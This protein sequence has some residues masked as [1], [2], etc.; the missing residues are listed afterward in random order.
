[1]RIGLDGIVL[2]NLA[3]GSQ[4]YFE[5]LLI[6]LSAQPTQDEFVVFAD[7]QV[8]RAAALP[9]PKNFFYQNVATQRGFP[10][11]MQQQLFHAWNV[12]GALDVLHSAVFVPPVWYQPP[13]VATIFDLAFDLFPETTKWTGRG[14]RKLFIRPGIAQASRVITLAESTKRDLVARFRIAADKIRVIYPCARAIFRPA[15]D[16]DAIAAHYHLPDQYVLF[17]GTLERRK[18]I[19]TLVRAFA[20]ARRMANLE[21]ALVLVGRR[22]WL[23]DDIFRAVEAS[24]ARD[25]V[26]FL[27]DVPDVHLPALYSRAELFAYLSLYEGFGLPVLEAMSCGAP[28]LAANTSALPEVV[29]AAGLLV[30]P[31]DVPA[32][33][34]TIGHILTDRDLRAAMR[35]RGF[36]RARLFSQER[37]MKQT[38]EVYRDAAGV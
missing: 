24:D 37:F 34:S 8:A 31:R 20:Q 23:Y 26:I 35:E 19:T 5:Q 10:A 11:V 3:A 6:G 7:L 4:R 16:S 27:E 22:G 38:L 12:S 15:P 25:R 13:S 1:M 17:V 18:N 36:A 30:D 21:H 29:G 28:V 14:W 32:I 2:R 9:R 33:A